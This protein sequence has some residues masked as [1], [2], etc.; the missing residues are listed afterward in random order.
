MQTMI[1]YLLTWVPFFWINWKLA[2]WLL[3][4]RKRIE[5]LE[6]ENV[7]LRKEVERMRERLE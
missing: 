4:D 3:E 5:R 6:A 7:L 1:F 2:D